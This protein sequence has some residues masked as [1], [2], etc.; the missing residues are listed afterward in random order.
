MTPYTP[1]IG[2]YQESLGP[3]AVAG[4]NGVNGGRVAGIKG[5]MGA[6]RN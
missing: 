6:S 4:I 1:H 5:I 2:D 3:V